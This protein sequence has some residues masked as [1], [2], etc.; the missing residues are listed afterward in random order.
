MGKI[1]PPALTPPEQSSR[2]AQLSFHRQA[3]NE[4][5]VEERACRASRGSRVV[6]LEWTYEEEGAGERQGG[7]AAPRNSAIPAR[8]KVDAPS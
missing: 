1:S 8:A 6:A 5:T 7:V 4:E 2:R 3:K